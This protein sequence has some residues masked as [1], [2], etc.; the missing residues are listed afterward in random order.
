MGENL[1]RSANVVST[2]DSG[3]TEPTCMLWFTPVRKKNYVKRETNSTAEKI[4]NGCGGL[5][6]RKDCNFKNVKGK[7]GHISKV[8]KYSKSQLIL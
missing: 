8:C 7:V 4:C 2:T 5:H 3:P 1:K 6:L